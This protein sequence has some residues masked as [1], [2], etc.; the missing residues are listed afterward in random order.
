MG[1]SLNDPY[2]RQP[3]ALTGE[4]MNKAIDPYFDMFRNKRWLFGQ[5]VMGQFTIG[6]TKAQQPAVAAEGDN[7]ATFEDINSLRNL[8]GLPVA[9]SRLMDSAGETL[10]HILGR[11]K[12]EVKNFEVNGDLD[13]DLYHALYDY[14]SD[15]GEMPYGT[16]KAR[17]G[18]PYNWISDRLADELGVT[19][20]NSGMIMPEADVLNTFE[21]MS[22]F[23]APAV[24]EGGCNATMEGEYCPE[25]GLAECGGMYEMGTVAGGMAPV[26]GEGDAVLARIKSLALL[27]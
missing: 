3:G 8:A 4:N 19:E 18:D 14:Y 15:N 27:K 11:F 23:D 26:I 25:H 10:Q 16:M 2:L 1:K 7:L 17:T 12:H 13:D 20:S 9:E 24:Q 6:V 22:G 21:V 5:P